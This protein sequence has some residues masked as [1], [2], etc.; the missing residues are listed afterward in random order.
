MSDIYTLD[1]KELFVK[2][3]CPPI[4]RKRVIMSFSIKDKMYV[5]FTQ[6]YNK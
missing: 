5:P 6:I 4:T 1:I 3:S 2:M